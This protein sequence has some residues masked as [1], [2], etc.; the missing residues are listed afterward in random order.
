MALNKNIVI[1]F[2][3]VLFMRGEAQWIFRLT[4][5]LRLVFLQDKLSPVQFPAIFAFSNKEI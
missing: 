4:Y 3:F 2:I 5:G 1:L